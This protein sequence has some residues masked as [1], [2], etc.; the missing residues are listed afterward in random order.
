MPLLGF[1]HQLCF[2]YLPVESGCGQDACLI[3]PWW[4][5]T[6]VS[7]R[8]GPYDFSGYV[9]EIHKVGGRLGQLSFHP[10]RCLAGGF[11]YLLA[12]LTVLLRLPTRP[13]PTLGQLSASGPPG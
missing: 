2:N 4:S 7:G 8:L 3:R 9:T 11:L 12:Q 10:P 6:C 13:V 5:V 1:L